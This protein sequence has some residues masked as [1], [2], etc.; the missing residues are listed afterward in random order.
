MDSKIYLRMT[1]LCLFECRVHAQLT[2]C[3]CK[4][5]AISQSLFKPQFKFE[6]EKFVFNQPFVDFV[7]LVNGLHL[8][9]MLPNKERSVT[10]TG[11]EFNIANM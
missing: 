1:F 5:M 8:L 9:Q 6:M 3:S 10:C 4:V 11:K 7:F 2:K